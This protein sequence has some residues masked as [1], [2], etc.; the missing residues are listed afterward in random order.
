M[1]GP[2]L[3]YTARDWPLTTAQWKQQCAYAP[4]VL[5]KSGSGLFEQLDRGVIKEPSEKAFAAAAK[6]H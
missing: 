2:V 4:C 1:S 6:A 5:D 3:Y